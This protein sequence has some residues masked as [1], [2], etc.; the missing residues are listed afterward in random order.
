MR[1]VASWRL[2]ATHLNLLTKDIG[3]GFEVYRGARR[4]LSTTVDGF[5][6]HALACDLRNVNNS[7]S[8]SL[9]HYG[10]TLDQVADD[11]KGIVDSTGQVKVIVVGHDWGSATVQ[12]CLQC[13]RPSSFCRAEARRRRSPLS[14][15]LPFLSFRF[16]LQAF[17]HPL[18]L[19]ASNRIQSHPIHCRVHCAPDPS[20]PSA[21][22]D[23]S[24]GFRPSRSSTRRTSRR[25][26]LSRCRTWSSTDGALP[27]LPRRDAMSPHCTDSSSSRSDGLQSFPVAP[28]WR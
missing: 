21:P 12:V 16:V 10:Y 9:G 20:E 15:S 22:S 17:V 23:P 19:F 2:P 8:T 14:L 7:Q 4:T 25:W 11:L 13:V 26:S 3:V 27:S 1:F 28:Q 24:G 6:Y 5:R 18:L